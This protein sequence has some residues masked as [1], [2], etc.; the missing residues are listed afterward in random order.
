MKTIGL[1]FSEAL[2]AMKQGV[3]V[4]RKVIKNDTVI[5]IYKKRLFQLCLSTGIRYSY[6]PSNKDLLTNDWELSKDFNN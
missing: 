6:I 5:I 3:S 1:S 2:D 4:K